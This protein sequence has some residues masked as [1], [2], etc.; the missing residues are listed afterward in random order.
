MSLDIEVRPIKL[1]PES[2]AKR[3]EYLRSPFESSY[4][5]TM[6]LLN[7]ELTMLRASNVVLQLDVK[8]RSITRDGRLRSDARVDGPG[9]ILSFDTPEHG[10]LTYDTDR[11]VHWHDNLRAIALGLESLRRVERYGIADRG[12]QYAGYRELGSGIALGPTKLT[13]DVAARLLADAYA[14][15]DVSPIDWMDLL[16]FWSDAKTRDPVWRRLAQVHHPD[17]GGDGE[18]FAQLVEARD[19]LDVTCKVTRT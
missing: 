3:D 4:T 14:Q 7:R 1:I 12:Q 18:L 13:A 11:F 15:L 10:T 16:S 17:H 8:E 19:V 2:W 6:R 5:S 9:V